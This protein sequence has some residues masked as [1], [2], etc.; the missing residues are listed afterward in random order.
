[1]L[2]NRIHIPEQVLRLSFDTGKTRQN[3]ML[4]LGVRIS[5]AGFIHEKKMYR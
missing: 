4:F 5:A 3:K 2:L 1:M